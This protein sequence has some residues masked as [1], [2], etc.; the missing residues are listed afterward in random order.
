MSANRTT[1]WA[2][3][4]NSLLQS[5][6]ESMGSNVSPAKR[7]LAETIATVQCELA[8]LQDKLAGS[9]RG[10]DNADLTL[11]LRLSGSVTELMSSAGLG[12]QQ[13]TTNQDGGDALKKLTDMFNNIVRANEEDEAAG[14]F[15]IGGVLV[16]DPAAI[17]LE[18]WIYALEQMRDNPPPLV[19][20]AS[21]A[22]ATPA[23]ASPA[24]P[25]ANVVD[26]QRGV[27]RAPPIPTP[28]PIVAEPTSTQRFLEW[29]AAGGNGDSW[30]AGPNWPRLR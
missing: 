30:S 1:Q 2:T 26:L 11:F 20:A 4:Y 8:V 6:L 16:T 7:A 22:P 25:A 29:S 19:A 18:R 5:H 9:G 15:H 28:A 10:G 17:V 13:T 12:Q 27:R 3:K 24:S 14:I 23:P 21:P